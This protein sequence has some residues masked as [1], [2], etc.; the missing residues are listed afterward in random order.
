LFSKESLWD[1]P[2]EKRAKMGHL[3]S[4]ER[5][6][7]EIRPKKARCHANGV[8]LVRSATHRS[9]KTMQTMWH[10]PVAPQRPP[11]KRAHERSISAIE[12]QGI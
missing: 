10:D 11:L 8:V 6:K 9:F 4:N 3:A 1:V 12:L 7:S 2:Y 5:R